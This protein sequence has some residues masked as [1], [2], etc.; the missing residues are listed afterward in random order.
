MA[1]PIN[2]VM[3]MVDRNGPIGR[4]TAIIRK[5]A[6]RV[7]RQSVSAPGGHGPNNGTPGA[8]N[9]FAQYAF[10][11]ITVTTAD[12][13]YSVNVLTQAYADTV[14]FAP[15]VGAKITMTGWEPAGRSQGIGGAN[16][17][18]ADNPNGAAIAR[19][20]SFTPQQIT[21]DGATD[22]FRDANGKELWQ[23]APPVAY[24]TRTRDEVPAPKK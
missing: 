4:P 24:S 10:L 14:K 17:R 23:L 1:K 21:V 22:K 20:A 11:S 16:P 5:S 3:R 19:L 9:P 18:I 8:A 6:G 15:A 2:C 7:I 13:T 12:K